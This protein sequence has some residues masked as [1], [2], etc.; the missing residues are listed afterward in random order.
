[1]GA[2]V[3]FSLDKAISHCKG[4]FRIP[5][6]FCFMALGDWF[7]WTQLANPLCWQLAPVSAGGSRV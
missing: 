5:A 1:M 7:L 3:I 4:Y 6:V 2:R